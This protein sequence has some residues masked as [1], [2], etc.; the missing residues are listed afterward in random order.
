MNIRDFNSTL[1][2]I[3]KCIRFFLSMIDKKIILGLFITIFLGACASPTA[4]LGPAYTFTSTGNAYQAGLTYSSNEIITKHTGKS[5][6]ENIKKITEK[7][8]K[9]EKNIM[10]VTLESDEFYNLV[11][12]NIKKTRR[13]INFNQ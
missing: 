2:C 10:K 9:K 6:I 7:K 4:M 12:N 13:L 8:R 5:A 3:L 1:S 11:E